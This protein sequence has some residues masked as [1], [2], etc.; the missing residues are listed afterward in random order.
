MSAIFFLEVSYVSPFIFSRS[1]GGVSI[2]TA[3]RTTTHVKKENIAKYRKFRS[4]IWYQIPSTV[5]VDFFISN[6]SRIIPA[7]NPPTKAASAPLAFILLQKRPRRKTE[8][9]GGA[10]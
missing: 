6:P 2:L 9:M 8:A 1:G 10:I 4:A 5:N 7:M 3:I